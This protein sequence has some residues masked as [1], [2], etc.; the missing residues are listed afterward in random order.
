MY[1]IF[2][3]PEDDKLA[4]NWISYV[5]EDLKGFKTQLTMNYIVIQRE[6]T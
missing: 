2:I 6:L 1:N 4:K 3:L 5:G